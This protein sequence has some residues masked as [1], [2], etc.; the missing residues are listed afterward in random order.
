MQTVLIKKY[1]NGKLYIPKGNTEPVGYQTLVSIVA[2][3][4]K[5]KSVKIIDSTN[6]ND[7]T[8]ETL[9]PALNMVEFTAERL[10][11]LFRG[12]DV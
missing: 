3:I 1:P 8:V 7:I 10:E 12:N 6:G 4:R 2:I 5:G 9:V 11:E